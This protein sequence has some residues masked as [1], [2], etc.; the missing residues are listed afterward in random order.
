LTSEIQQLRAQ[1]LEELELANALERMPGCR[2][3]ARALMAKGAAYLWARARIAWPQ[4]SEEEAR[5]LMRL[6]GRPAHDPFN[7]RAAEEA[8]LYGFFEGR[9]NV[10][11]LMANL[12]LVVNDL[13]VPDLLD[14]QRRPM[15]LECS[16][17]AGFSLE[18][19]R[20]QMG[21]AR[22]HK[23][24]VAGPGEALRAK[25]DWLKFPWH[26]VRQM[27]EQ[28]RRPLHPLEGLGPWS[29]QRR[30]EF[31]REGGVF[32][33]CE[34]RLR[35]PLGPDFLPWMDPRHLWVARPESPFAQEAMDAGRPVCTGISGVTLQFF[36]FALML[37]EPAD[38]AL[39]LVCL[40][41][42]VPVKAHS[43]WEV[44]AVAEHYQRALV[45][46][47]GPRQLIPQVPALLARPARP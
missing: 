28:T 1:E 24:R 39:A 12:W 20:E 11:E 22:A 30:G 4:A 13:L 35:S 40:A 17:Q 44:L 15:A 3:V 38:A 21:L 32:S 36:E 46:T 2:E 16:A 37:G 45:R 26:P 27:Q 33:P 8:D 10:R 19:L 42:L 6:C 34:A 29:R 9:G 7:G 47:D 31:E 23:D 25:E 41:Y 14:E 43:F 18:R 5:R